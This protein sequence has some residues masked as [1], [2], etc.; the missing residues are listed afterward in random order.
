[1]Y[2]DIKYK[3]TMQG[4]VMA[5]WWNGFSSTALAI[6]INFFSHF[7]NDAD[8]PLAAHDLCKD[9]KFL[10]KNPDEPTE[11]GLFC[12]HFML[13]LIASAHFGFISGHVEIPLLN[14][15]ALAAGRDMECIIGLAAA[16]LEHAISFIKDSTIDVKEILAESSDRKMKIKLPKVLNKATRWETSSMFSFSPLHW[17]DDTMA[18]KEAVLKHGPTWLLSTFGAI[19]CVRNA[20]ASG[21]TSSE[22]PNGDEDVNSGLHHAKDTHHL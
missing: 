16:A 18:D 2:P 21:N 17:G 13:E 20:K 19:H 15:H 1:M 11:E 8:I 9:Y 5:I 3:V 4:S 7:D 6:M 14:T 22:G 12:S 10:H